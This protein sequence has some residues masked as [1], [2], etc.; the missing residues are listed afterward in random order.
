MVHRRL[1]DFAVIG[2]M[3]AGTT[4]L[5]SLLERV[6]GVCMPTMKETDFFV[7]QKNLH[8]GIDW[9]TRQFPHSDRLCGDIS[10]N[11]SKRDLFPGVAERLYAAAP[12]AKIIYVVRDPLERAISQYRHSYLAGQDLPLPGKLAGTRDGEHIAAGSRYAYQIEPYLRLFGEPAVLIVDFV[13]LCA[14]PLAVVTR[15]A[16]FA[17]LV[18]VHVR[19]GA[20]AAA[21]SSESLGR[22]PGWWLKLREHPVGER[23]RASV[24][25]ALIQTVKFGLSARTTRREVPRFGADERAELAAMLHEDSERFRALTGISFGRVTA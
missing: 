24:P 8:R 12:N 14:E 1:P 11:Y 13:E 2:A 10:P 5:Q 17:G 19:P 23:I 25:R 7:A 3:R 20:A 16:R 21:N 9:Y 22:M 18:E 4:T 6:D 15:I